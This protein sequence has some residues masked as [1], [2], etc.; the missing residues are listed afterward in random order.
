MAMSQWAPP[1]AD[2]NTRP[3]LLAKPPP[4]T[5][6][7]CQN[8]PAWE[9]KG[10]REGQRMASR[11]EAPPA[12]NEIITPWSHAKPPLPED[13][14]TMASCQNPH[15]L[16]RQTASRRRQLQT[17][18]RR[19]QL[20]TRS[21]HHGVMPKPP[22]LGVRGALAKG[23]TERGNWEAKGCY[24]APS[25]ETTPQVDIPGPT[26]RRWGELPH[27]RLGIA[28]WTH[29]ANSKGICFPPRGLDAEK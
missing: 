4:P 19:R 24:V 21:S 1:A 14:H 5:M 12:A 10:P 8:S 28:A 2:E 15:C 29:L 13:Q 27:R 22:L 20:Q 11:Q 23:K 3:L 9:G 16:A 6:A 17:A 25:G 26:S 7:S 18:S